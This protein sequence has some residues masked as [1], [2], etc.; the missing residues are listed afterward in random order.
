MDVRAGSESLCI[1]DRYPFLN[2]DLGPYDMSDRIDLAG[3]IFE[4]GGLVI[5]RE[6]DGSGRS[7]PLFGNDDFGYIVGDKIRFGLTIIVFTVQEHD[8]VGILFDRPGFAQIRHT[9]SVSV[10]AFTGPV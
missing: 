9:W 4:R 5:E 10:S 1:D 2:A 3:E 6:F 7:V 8:N